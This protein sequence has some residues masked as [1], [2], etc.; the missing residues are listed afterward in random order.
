MSDKQ[1]E[2]QNREKQ[3]P[4][5]EGQD[6]GGGSKNRQGQVEDHDTQ[7]KAPEGPGNRDRN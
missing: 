5:R 7:R 3:N 2:E 1:R 6:H 4:S